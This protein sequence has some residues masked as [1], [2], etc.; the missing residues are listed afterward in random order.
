MP[1]IAPSGQ[2][3]ATASHP[4]DP[5]AS[6]DTSSRSHERRARPTERAG[7]SRSCDG[8]ALRDDARETLWRRIAERAVR[9]RQEHR[10]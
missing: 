2:L 6:D 7:G 4:E 5:M 10:R 1:R 8:D 3:N 9:I